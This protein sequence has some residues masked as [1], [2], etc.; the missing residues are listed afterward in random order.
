MNELFRLLSGSFPFHQSSSSSC[1]QCEYNNDAITP[2]RRCDLNKNEL[3]PQSESQSLITS[4]TQPVL[5][6]PGS[7][8]AS[9]VS[10]AVVYFVPIFVKP[11]FTALGLLFYGNQRPTQTHPHPGLFSPLLSNLYILSP[12]GRSSALNDSI[13]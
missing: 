10:R 7:P 12:S 13:S 6:F 11:K 2:L 5:S 1:T 8:S 9:K 3:D 4:A